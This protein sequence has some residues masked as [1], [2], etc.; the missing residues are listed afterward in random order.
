MAKIHRSALVEYS[1]EQMFELVNDV[2]NYPHFMKGC[3]A[4][5]VLEKDENSLVGELKLS[6]AGINQTLVTRNILDYPSSISM[7][8]VKGNF[9]HFSARWDFLQLTDTASKV[10]L[11]MEFEIKPG[12]VDLALEKL[13]SVSGNNLVD[14]L[15]GRAKL[16]YGS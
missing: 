10:S 12:I 7:E 9:T 3:V 16:V 2:E 8:L 11:R 14:A 15:V 13:I 5:K 6:K 4:A 1:A